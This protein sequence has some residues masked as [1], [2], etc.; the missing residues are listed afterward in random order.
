MKTATQPEH[1]QED[2]TP[3]EVC[4]ELAD[5]GDVLGLLDYLQD[6]A[7]DAVLLSSLPTI[8]HCI[9]GKAKR[10]LSGL[11]EDSFARVFSLALFLLVK[12]Q[13]YICARLQ[14]SQD[15]GSHALSQLPADLIDDGWL[16]RAEK[17]S[18]FIAEMASTRAR[19]QHVERLHREGQR[20]G[21]NLDILAAPSPTNGDR[22]GAAP[23]GPPGR[24]GR[25]ARFPDPY[26]FT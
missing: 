9:R 18:R 17:L 15:A 12:V 3:Q 25:G 20:T 5:R 24:N 1:K 6:E 8:S 21:L 22:A 7:N 19:V 10:D 14:E 11:V 26:P 16:T 2:P 23:G 13:L 4:K